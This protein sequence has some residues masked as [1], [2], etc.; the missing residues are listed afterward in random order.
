M[1][2]QEMED[3]LRST[4]AAAAKEGQVALV[5]VKMQRLADLSETLRERHGLL[6][7]RL[8]R[9]LTPAHPQPP[10]TQIE[11][12]RTAMSPLA[13]R[14]DEIIDTLEALARMQDDTIA[15]LEI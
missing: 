8:G 14:L 6:I 13:E 9:V 4:V 15:R 2:E 10:L 12:D 11:T 5:N 1:H 3:G 7:D